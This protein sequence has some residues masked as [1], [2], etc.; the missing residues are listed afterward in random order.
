LIADPGWRK[1]SESTSNCGWKV[2]VPG[3][4]YPALPAYASTCPVRASMIPPASSLMFRPIRPLI[5]VRSAFGM[6]YWFRSASG[7]FE[8]GARAATRSH[9]SS[10]CC[11]PQ[12]SVVVT[13]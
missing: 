2:L 1:P 5:H 11:M 9:F 7:F 4:V 13:V 12:S 8:L 6:L 10:V 3:W